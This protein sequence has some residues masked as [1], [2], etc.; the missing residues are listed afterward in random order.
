MAGRGRGLA[1]APSLTDLMLKR[2]ILHSSFVGTQAI[3]A[4]GHLLLLPPF[5]KQFAMGVAPLPR[6]TPACALSSLCKE[7]NMR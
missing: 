5:L 7:P 3:Q 6:N 1:V 4:V 2:C